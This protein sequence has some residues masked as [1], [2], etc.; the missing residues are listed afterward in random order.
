MIPP[1]KIMLLGELA[2]GK[3]SLVRR[4][5]FDRFESAYKSTIGVDLY[6]CQIIVP[7]GQGESAVDVVIWDTDGN[8]SQSIF[9]H[10]Y[11]KGATAAL[12]VGDVTRQQTLESMVSLADAFGEALPGRPLHFALNK[13]DLLEEK[14]PLALP[15]RLADT[16]LPLIQTSAKLGAN[17]RHAFNETTAAIVRRGL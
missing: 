4:L 10:I 3:S 14:E 11:V 5:V 17:V 16:P 7:T 15:R 9:R 1:K 2:V 13:V 12:I 8:F 6:T